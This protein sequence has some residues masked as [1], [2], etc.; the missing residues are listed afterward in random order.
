MNRG[1]IT[2]TTDFGHTDPYV[3]IIKGV[4]FG[5]NPNATVIDL[6]HNVPPQDVFC[7]ALVLTSAVQYFPQGTIHVGVVDPGVGS[8]RRPLLIEAEGSFYI[9]PDNGLLSFAVKEKKITSI[10]ELRNDAYFLKPTSATFHGRD[11]FA[12]VAAHLSLGIA[13]KALG[14][15]VDKFVTIDWPRLSERNGSLEGEIIYIDRFGNLVTN[16]RAEDLQPFT[17]GGLTISVR[18]HKLYGLNS[19][20]ASGAEKELSALIDSWG[21]MEIAQFRGSAQAFSGAQRG[22]KIFVHHAG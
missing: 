5:I 22:D 13:A 16:I 10:I 3:G 11:I 14:N 8:K 1:V 9:G 19:T 6:S 18:G 7:A 15:P 2:L 4:I 20:Y 12:P 21:L 17:A